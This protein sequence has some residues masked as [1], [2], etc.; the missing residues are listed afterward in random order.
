[1]KSSI[2]FILFSVVSHWGWAQCKSVKTTVDKFT[3]T[4]VRTASVMIGSINV[5]TGGTKWLLDFNQEAGVT[6]LQTNI[7]M[8]GEFNQVLGEDTKFLMLLSN[9]EVVELTNKVPA[10]P[11]TKAIAGS[12]VVHIYTNY[13]LTL[14][15]SKAQLEQLAAAATVEVKVTVP[16]Q[17]I[18]SPKISKKDGQE[19]TNISKCL[20]ETA[21]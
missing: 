7:A 4:E 2:L 14:Q 17:K 21:Q 16:D 12:G 8:I 13:T 3:K 19:I 18:K 15:P 11:V 5:I 9:D 1:M 6:T 10:K 20:Q